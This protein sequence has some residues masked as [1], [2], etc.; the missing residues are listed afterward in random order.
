MFVGNELV[1]VHYDESIQIAPGPASFL[2]KILPSN[3]AGKH[4]AKITA[5]V[6][7]EEPVSF[8][9]PL[10]VREWVEVP[11]AKRPLPKGAVVASG[12]MVMARA[13]L[14]ELPIDAARDVEQ[15]VGYETKHP[16]GHGEVFRKKKLSIPPMI[17]RGQRVTV[18]YRT[19]M[20]EATASGVALEDGVEGQRIRI[21]NE[22]SKKT[23][24]GTVMNP[25]LVKVI[26]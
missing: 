14:S 6:S 20:L 12:D 9:V 15:I 11:V 16:I 23:V 26:P 22:S 13:D 5:Q 3:K 19:S 7:D 10:T 17:E 2:A 24:S 25:G 4:T 21:R 8:T 1:Q 18:M